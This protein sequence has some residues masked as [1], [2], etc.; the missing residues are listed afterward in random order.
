MWNSSINVS[1][2]SGILKDDVLSCHVCYAGDEWNGT[3]PSIALEERP[4]ITLR[5]STCTLA[6][7]WGLGSSSARPTIMASLDFYF[8]S[9]SLNRPWSVSTVVRALQM[10]ACW[11]LVLSQPDPGMGTCNAAAPFRHEQV[12]RINGSTSTA[13]NE[14]SPGAVP[15]DYENVRIPSFMA[16]HCQAISPIT[17]NQIY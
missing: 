6:L 10:P 13:A 15:Y 14:W 16:I 7:G 5:S 1:L 8:I 17:C 9:P 11:L 3:L 4:V 12:G 2:I